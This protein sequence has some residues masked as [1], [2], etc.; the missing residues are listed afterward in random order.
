MTGRRDEQGRELH[1]PEP[2]VDHLRAATR[3]RGVDARR[4]EWSR[5]EEAASVFYFELGRDLS[6]ST[7]AATHLRVED[8]QSCVV[9]LRRVLFSLTKVG[10]AFQVRSQQKYSRKDDREMHHQ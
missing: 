6:D 5:G 1:E 2:K 7:D 8:E 4:R 3:S 9:A 10:C